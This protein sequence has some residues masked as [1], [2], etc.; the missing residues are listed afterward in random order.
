Q[1][2]GSVGLSTAERQPPVYPAGGLSALLAA[3]T[4][5]PCFKNYR[6]QGLDCCCL[7]ASYMVLLL[8]F[9]LSFSCITYLTSYHWTYISIFK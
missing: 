6:G 3:L 5:K 2:T 7:F 1:K 4:P 8:D 9:P